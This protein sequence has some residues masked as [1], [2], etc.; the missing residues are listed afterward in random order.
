[1]DS[2]RRGPDNLSGLGL[3]QVIS[4]LSPS[5]DGGG[6]VN[7][8]YPYFCVLGPQF[9]LVKFEATITHPAFGLDQVIS[10]QKG[11]VAVGK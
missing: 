10:G 1:M 6:V 9:D 5:F 11:G 7:T 4:W 3:D 2:N 8:T